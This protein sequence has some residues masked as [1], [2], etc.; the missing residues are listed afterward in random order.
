MR[1]SGFVPVL[2][3]LAASCSS[4]LPSPVQPQPAATEVHWNKPPLQPNHFA[5]LPLGSVKPAGWLKQQLRIQADG[6][7]GH[8]D[9]FWPDVGA[10][11][12]WLGGSGESWERGPYYLDGLLPLAYLLEDPGLIAKAKKWVDWTLDNQRPSGAI[13]PDPSKGAYAQEWQRTDW[14]PNMVMLKVLT[15]Y[16]EATGDPRVIPVMTKYFQ[17]HLEHAEEAPL[18]RWAQMRWAE[19]L[20]SI[21]W[22]YNRT[23]ESSLLDLARK[24]QLQSYDWRGHFANFQWPGKVTRQEADLRTHVVN[25]AMAM[26]TSAVWWQI[27]GQAED[28]NAIHQLLDV[29]DRHHLLPNGVHSGDEH[30]AGK[31][32][33]QGTELC[34]VVEGMFS[35][36]VLNSILGEPPFGDRL[37]RITFNAL[38]ATFKKDMWAHQYDQQPNQVKCSV[39]KNRNWT[40]NGPDSNLFGLEPNFGC[41]TANMHQGW[42]K[43]VSHMWMATRGGG[44]AAVAYGPSRVDARVADGTLVTILEETEYPF[45]DSIRLTVYPEERATFPLELRIPSWT[46]NPTITAAGEPVAG[47]RPGTYHKL[48]RAWES[49]DTIEIR[50][51]MPV[52]SERHFQDSVVLRRGPV[53]FGLKIGEEWIKVKGDEPHADWEVHPTTPWNYGLLLDPANPAEGIKM[54]VRP[55]SG[56]PF[57]PE[58]APVVIEARARRVPGWKLVN[59]SAGPLPPSPVKSAEPEETVTL[60]PYGATNLRVT[61][62]PLV[63]P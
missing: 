46:A 8:L 45:G 47:V 62:F 60:L 15:Q 22:L 63:A 3:L 44:L 16:H 53:V 38:P 18:V 27:S 56:T 50:F 42:P 55:V 10:N 13:G 5:P 48:E 24:L 28:R 11:S 25:N 29:M 26:K 12:G 32:P 1:L 35:L 19:E 9:E 21:V 30:Y 17:Y 36:E 57:S 23:G 31:D 52:E 6:L 40:T 34:A 7:S 2:A 49:G 54:D 61:A 33:S 41:C 20:L 43:F 4:R 14:W 51:P 58:S 59:S 37:E 39:D